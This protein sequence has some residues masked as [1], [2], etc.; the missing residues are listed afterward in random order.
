MEI[1]TYDP[2]ANAARLE[3]HM[4]L[5]IRRAWQIAWTFGKFFALR[6]WTSRPWLP[7]RLTESERE[8][9]CARNLSSGLA[10]L[11]PTFIKIGQALSTR[12]DVLPRTYVKE[13]TRLQD[14]VPAFDTQVALA[15]IEQEL[16]KPLA[17]LFAQFDPDPISAASIGQ[18]YPAR[19][20]EGDR[21]VVKVQRPN[22]PWNLSID[23]ALLRLLAERVQRFLANQKRRRKPAPGSLSWRGSL[24]AKDM[25]YVAI[26][27]QFGKSLFDQ[28][29]FVL[30]GHN[31]DRFRENFAHFE[32]VRSPI[33]YWELTT[34]RV[35]TLEHIDGVKFN[36]VAGIEKM[37]VDFHQ[38]VVLGVRAF[39]KQLL[40]DGFF[41]ADTHPGN[42]FVT[43]RGE[44]VY[45]DWGMTDTVP[46]PTQ[47]K[48][49]DIFLH[50]MRGEYD[51]LA[52]D[53]V[54]LE[55]FPPDLDRS[56]LIPVLTD[57][58][59]TQLG[60]RGQLMSMN[61]IIE[62]ISDVLYLY[63][64][65]LPERFSFMMRTVGTME[66]VVL[67][68]W[69]TFRFLDIG[70]PYAAK[71]LLTIPDTAIRDRLAAD[72][73]TDGRLDLARLAETVHLAAL[74][75]SFDVKDFMPEAAL[76][77]ISDEGQVLRDAIT[78]ALESADA[79]DV[80]LL[81]DLT[82]L[83]PT[84]SRRIFGAA[85]E[86][87]ELLLARHGSGMQPLF[88]LSA[89]WLEAPLGRAAAGQLGMAVGG[90]WNPAFMSQLA[91]LGEL[92]LAQGIDLKPL[93]QAIVGLVLS[94]DGDPWR[95]VGVEIALDG[96]DRSRLVGFLLNLVAH[97]GVGLD[98][99]A[100]AAGTALL[101][102]L[103]QGRSMRRKAF[104]VLRRRILGGS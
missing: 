3:Q 25:P 82:A 21:V 5:A 29:D 88:D 48:L 38:A 74:E 83:D 85:L 13:L 10:S 70:M 37:G 32:K 98:L 14:R 91:D 61:Q 28:T 100:G 15:T 102:L 68:T 34:R 30:E 103:P 51:A 54:D 49:V 23:L 36:D 47:L 76:W 43:P 16:G 40:E 12:P 86:T 94:P 89:A 45:I 73:I 35:L 56:M 78:A 41:H 58:Y 7:H 67:E 64:F 87:C 96:G 27:D 50:M 8:L 33:V 101:A 60:K 66:G 2:A 90:T 18:V 4:G 80:A 44:V 79:A 17:E 42:I 46:R 11:G 26:L 75:Q 9:A 6:W 97:D 99:M 57:I 77:L 63:P 31:A 93:V 84:R 104:E 81:G 72:L 69:P 53:L 19:T 24:F 39:I 95:E 22:L 92:A 52:E 62:R 71:L 59:E 55:M 20:L 1:L 65:R